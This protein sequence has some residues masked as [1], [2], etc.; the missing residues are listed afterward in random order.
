MADDLLLHEPFENPARQRV[1]VPFGMWAFL[2]TEILFFA[3]IFLFYAHSRWNGGQA[4]LE[5]AKE[6]AFWYGTIN[7]AILMTSSLAMA[8]AERANRLSVMPLVRAML[9]LTILLGTVF[10]VVKGLE[11]HKDVSEHLVPGPHF[12]LEHGPAEQFWAFYWTA[13][14]VHAVHLTIGIGAVMRLAWIDWRSDLSRRDTL[15]EA[16]A[17][18]LHLVDIIWLTLYPLLYLAGRQ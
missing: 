13:T 18:Y 11:Y 1:A 6:S 12:K 4:F 15:I 5:G 9:W 10:L 8:I 7:T 16:T 14:G 2:T 17:L 3:G